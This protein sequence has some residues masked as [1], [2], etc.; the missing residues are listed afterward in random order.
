[1]ELG[2]S[3]KYL[4]RI[5]ALW[6]LTEAGLGGVFHAFKMPFTGLIIAGMSVVYIS[7]FSFL[8]KGKYSNIIKATFIVLIIKMLISPHT[9]PTAYIAVLFQ[10]MMGYAIFSVFG[11]SRISV[12]IFSF[13]AMME[14]GLQKILTMTLFYGLSI[15]ESIDSFYNYL[16]KELPIDFDYSG[17]KLL[18]L[19]Y[20]SLYFFGA[21]LFAVFSLKVIRNL[22]QD[23]KSI[24]EEYQSHVFV[25][26]NSDPKKKEKLIGNRTRLFIILLFIIAVLLLFNPEL[27][28]GSA[29][30]VF[31]RAILV[32]VIW[33]V[34]LAPWVKHLF[35]KFLLKQKKKYA[36][37]LTQI[38]SFFPALKSIVSFTRTKYGK[39]NSI[40]KMNL[41]ISTVIFLTLHADF[42]Q[43]G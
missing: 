38:M 25:N 21:V 34:F 13:I 30:Y 11:F 27:G 3:K 42:E 41:F 2:E 22:K 8:S 6:A 32:I 35:E 33:Y 1:M 39:I 9:P 43:D 24:L 19:I 31:L 7:L 40:K 20:L 36:S 16:I 29:L 4:D 17:S 10:G 28:W 23:Q 5:I 18:I 14:S 26:K 15:W 12:F 37:D